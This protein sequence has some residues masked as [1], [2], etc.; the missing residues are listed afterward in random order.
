[1]NSFAILRTNVGLT[2]NIKIMIDSN[3]S[4][5]LDSIESNN[6]LCSDKFKKVKFNKKNYYDELISFFYKNLPSDIAYQIKYDNDVETMSDTFSKQYDELYQYGA[7]NIIDN[8]NY[9][10]EYEYFAPLYIDVNKIPSNF[11][12][13]RVDGPGIDLLTK[14]N[15][16]SDITNSLKF[17]KL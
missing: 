13:F 4:L 14:E 17:V 10:E 2:T 7:R 1:M 9:K 5:S 8:K 11:I 12:I 16:T 15:F 3:Y 6:D